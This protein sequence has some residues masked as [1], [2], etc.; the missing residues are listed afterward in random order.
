MDIFDKIDEFESKVSDQIKDKLSLFTKIMTDTDMYEKL[1][2]NQGNNEEVTP[3]AGTKDLVDEIK[4]DKK[5]G[6]KTKRIDPIDACINAHV[7]YQKCND[8]ENQDLEK[9]M[10]DYLSL[11]GWDK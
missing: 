10:E 3:D 1:I 11:M 2:L 5:V 8:I 7:A 9:N 4:S 6:A